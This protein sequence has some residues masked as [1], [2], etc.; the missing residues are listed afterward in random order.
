MQ[1]LS[2]TCNHCG[3]PLEVPEGAKFVTCT[4]CS[5]RLAVQRSGGAAYTRVLESLEQRTEQIADDVETLKLQ[6]ELDRLDREWMLERDQ[7]M[8][9][10][11][12][13]RRHFPSKAGSI[14]FMFVVIGFVILWMAIA[15]SE[16]VFLF[17]LLFI[18]VAVVL[19]FVRMQK[20]DQ[21]Q[22][23]RRQ[24]ERRRGQILREIDSR[25]P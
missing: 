4:H 2:L 14:L 21:Y 25:S 16:P 20:A 9:Q 6:S 8:V 3:A 5:S 11:K 13:G 12:H 18:A 10:D 24:Y 19:F 7:Y 15:R 17:G 23:H 22:R 1:L